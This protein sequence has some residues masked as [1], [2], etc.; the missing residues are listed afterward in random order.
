MGAETSSR[1]EGYP[2]SGGGSR[3]AVSLMALHLLYPLH[4]PH[5]IDLPHAADDAF[6]VLQIGD[7]YDDVDGGVGSCGFGFDVADV[8]VGVADDC[9]DLLQHARAVITEHN[10]LNG[11]PRLPYRGGANAAVLAPLNGDAA[12][13]LVHQVLDV[14]ARLGVHSHA[15]ATRHVADDLFAANR[16]TTSRAIDQQ[17][18]VTFNLDGRGVAAEDPSHYAGEAAGRLVGLVS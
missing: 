4:I 7:V 6:Q 11:E 3:I 5:A 10:K 15:L 14:C 17:I 13:R 9:R 1:N 16:I 2:P 8:G 12:L 18:V